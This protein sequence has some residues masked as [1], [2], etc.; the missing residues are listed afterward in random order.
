MLLMG[1]GRHGPVQMVGITDEIHAVT[2]LHHLGTIPWQGELSVTDDG[3]N[4]H[5]QVREQVCQVPDRRID[6][7]ADLVALH[8]DKIH[9]AAA[10]ILDIERTGNTQLVAD[11]G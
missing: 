3:E 7:R 4:G 6:N 1:K 11:R 9:P 10:H 2:R 8:T 5:R